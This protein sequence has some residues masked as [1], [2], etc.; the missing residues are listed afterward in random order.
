MRD[1]IELEWNGVPSVAI[2]AEPLVGSAEAMKKL[3]GMPDY[4]YIVVPYPVGS[5]SPE[6]IRNRAKEITPRIIELLTRQ[7]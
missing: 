1:A 5:M 6:E 3:S 2:I 4:P 7:T